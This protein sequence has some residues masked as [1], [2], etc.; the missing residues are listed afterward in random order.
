MIS[1][2]EVTVSL[3]RSPEEFK[4]FHCE[5]KDYTDFVQRP[6]EALQ[7]QNQNLG[8][9]Y[10]FKHKGSPIGYVTL[11]MGS[12][13]KTELPQERKEQKPF[14]K[15]PSLLLG[16]MARCLDLKGQGVGKI[17]VDFTIKKAYEL[18]QKI[19]CRL[20]IVDSERDVETRYQAYGFESIPPK[21][22]DETVLMF[23]DLG[24]RK[25]SAGI[26]FFI[27]RRLVARMRSFFRFL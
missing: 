9:T 27:Y 21:P 11:A 5:K 3:Y 14:G 4:G 22:K 25:Y 17:M 15:V 7:Y 19:G 26:S 2:D 23:F 6:E 24:L 12:L 8:V 18:A 16:Q 13:S 1:A 20:I 10:V